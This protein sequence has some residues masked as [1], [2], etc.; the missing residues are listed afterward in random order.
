MSH[1]HPGEGDSSGKTKIC[2]HSRWITFLSILFSSVATVIVWVLFFQTALSAGF[3]SYL[4]IHTEYFLQH[5]HAQMDSTTLQKI[6]EMA[7]NGTLLS[8]DDLWSFQGTF[9]QTIITVLIAL[10][11]ILGGFAFF[12]IK[13]SSNAKAREEATEEVK[14]YIE[15]KSFDKEVRD[16]INLKI[17]SSVN[18]KIGALQIDLASQIDLISAFATEI[19]EIKNKSDKIEQLEND[20]K[21]IKRHIA[22]LASAVS[23]LDKSEDNDSSLTL[24]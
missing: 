21:D 8:L 7:T 24:K 5:P 12:M 14:R 15:S 18:E 2:Y 20:F 6:G 19:E 3:S 10:N 16:I 4:G 11:A 13:Q 22:F 23:Q 9:Y 1:T 17:A